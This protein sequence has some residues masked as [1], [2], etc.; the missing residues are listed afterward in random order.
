[1]LTIDPLRCPRDY[2]LVLTTHA[3]MRADSI[4]VCG[5]F[6]RVIMA[7]F[8][9]VELCSELFLWSAVDTQ[10]FSTLAREHSSSCA[11]RR[12]GMATPY[13]LIG[14]A[15]MDLEQEFRM[16]TLE[17]AQQLSLE[18]CQKLAYVSS[19]TKEP[20]PPQCDYR[21]H[22]FSTLES[23]GKIGPLNLDFLENTLELIGRKDLLDVIMKY[24][25]KPIYKEV[26]S[27]K[28]SRSKGRSKQKGK[29]MHLGVSFDDMSTL[30]QYE[31]TFSFFLIQFAQMT[32]SM[33][34]A[35]ESK[36]VTHIKFAFSSAA[37][38]GDA[39]SRA[40]RKKL[41][42]RAGS[43]SDTSSRESSGMSIVYW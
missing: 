8:S 13:T 29:Q 19:C 40:L 28:K 3:H 5:S 34:S 41:S 12:Y 16:M 22:I 6:Q 43:N 33:R 9:G 15:H 7:R 35:L 4:E 39:V 18:E 23:R 20:V 11:Q 37:L 17:L 2:V 30:H 21:L 32:L 31:D 25:K 38:E 1:M 42:I 27:K 14:S 10:H 26:H 24:K 36:D